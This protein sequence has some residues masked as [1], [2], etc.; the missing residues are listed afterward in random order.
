MKPISETDFDQR[1]LRS[2][3]PTLVHFYAPWCGL[4]RLVDPLLLQLQKQYGEQLQ[5][6]RVNA[7]SSLRLAN[8]YRLRMLPT[9]LLVRNGE[10]WQRWETFQSRAQLYQQLQQAVQAIL[11]TPLV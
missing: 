2:P 10:I 1:V 4:C 8:R 7:D 11:A 3:L 9:L 6:V 5:V